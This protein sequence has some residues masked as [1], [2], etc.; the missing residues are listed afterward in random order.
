M[1]GVGWGGDS[2]GKVKLMISEGVI[3][4]EA[5]ESTRCS[6]EGFLPIPSTGFLHHSCLFS[7]ELWGGMDLREQDGYGQEKS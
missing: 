6:L 4:K 3:L 7:V 5:A 1:G 2:N